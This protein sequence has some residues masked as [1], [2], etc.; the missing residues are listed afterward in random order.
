MLTS[1]H[2]HTDWSDGEC[3]LAEQIAAAQTAGLDEVGISDHYILYPGGKMIDWSMEVERLGEY[4]AEIKT[5]AAETS[6]LTIRLGIEADFFPETVEELRRVVALH[7][8][9]FIIGSVHFVDGFPIDEVTEQWD[10]LTQDERNE[11]WRLYW[12]RIRQMAESR[13]FDFAAHLD[14]PKKFGHRPTVDL[15]AEREAALDA[16]AAGDMALEINTAGWYKPANE[17]Y[18]TLE[19]LKKARSRNI[20]LLINSDAHFPQHLTRDFDRA[21]ALVREAGYTEL[22]R[23]EQRMRYAVPFSL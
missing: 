8:F 13:V 23:Y 4:V 3:T 6:G 22:V 10:A 7:P 14:L 5:A 16:L 1:L 9:D 19:I 15:T 12:V 18:P 21:Y 2:N 17:A 20:P 11:M